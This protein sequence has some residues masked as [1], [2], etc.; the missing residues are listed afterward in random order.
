MFGPPTLWVHSRS[1]VAGDGTQSGSWPLGAAAV[2]LG[3]TL[4][5]TD[6]GIRP[7]ALARAVEERGF[8]SLYLPEHTHQP[9][10]T[11]PPGLVDGVALEDYRRSL[12]PFVALGAVSAVT[13]RIVI[14][15]G[16]TLVAQHDP[17]TLAKQ[18]ATIDFLSGGRFTLGVG[19]GWNRVEAADHGVDFARRRE[20]TADK[21]RCMQAL[22]SDGVDFRADAGDGADN[23][24]EVSDSGAVSGAGAGRVEDGYDGGAVSYEGEFASVSPSYA[25]PKPLR[26]P[27]P[28]T[29]VG[30]GAGPK[31]FAA[32]ADFA[33]GWMPVG[34]SGLLAALPELQAAFGAVGRDPATAE[35]VPFG[36]VPDA[37]KLE[38]L[39]G[40]GVQEVVL[41]V[42]NGPHDEVMRTLDAHAAFL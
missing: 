31:M 41:R 14:G 11:A 2:K 23:G 6:T 1:P 21:M 25:W 35:V 28:R 27:R 22:W 42:P 39:A 37:G 29:L 34:G 19:F 40:L 8:H 15:T 38:Y 10:G 17:I 24:V 18:I 4:F 32:I 13:E 3:I 5:G 9:V 12:D 30:G 33:D 26:R 7:A 20:I 36:T 16:I